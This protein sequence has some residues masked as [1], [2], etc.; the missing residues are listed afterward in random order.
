MKIKFLKREKHFKK[1]GSWLNLNFYWNLSICVILLATSLSL[2]LG[3]Y[4]F[5]QID[6]EYAPLEGGSGQIETVKKER[7][8]K[9]LEYFSLRKKKSDQISNSPSPVVDPSL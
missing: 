2:F 8:D 7:I 4:F 9:V 3:Y 1:E 6:K 5:M